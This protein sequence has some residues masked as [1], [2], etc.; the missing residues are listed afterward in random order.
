MNKY[1]RDFHSAE[2]PGYRVSAPTNDKPFWQRRDLPFVDLDLNLSVDADRQYLEENYH[3]LF[4]EAGSVNVR[5]WYE[6]PH[7]SEWK[8]LVLKNNTSAVELNK[9]KLVPETRPTAVQ[10][11]TVNVLEQLG[12]DIL[13]ASVLCLEPNGWLQPHRDQKINA[14]PPLNYFW[15]PL[16]QN[17]PSLKIWPYGYVESKPGHVYLFNNQDWIHSIR[18][19]QAHRRFV[20]IGR[21]A[22]E[23]LPKTVKT[24]VEEAIQDQWDQ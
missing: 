3:E 20:L 9:H 12:L 19:Q 10:I 24:L 13:Y 17:L 23:S 14:V 1:T 4:S 8:K 21:F 22:V 6:F 11:N 16:S 18:N 7:S 2:F 5:E 15:I